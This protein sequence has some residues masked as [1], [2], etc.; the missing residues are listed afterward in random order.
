VTEE[1]NGQVAE[2]GCS[3]ASP[4]LRV[5]LKAT[6]RRSWCSRASEPAALLGG[7]VGF[8]A[9]FDARLLASRGVTAATTLSK[10]D[11]RKPRTG[12]HAV[13]A[14]PRKIVASGE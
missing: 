9:R 12:G 4:A 7:I 5:S 13:D 8:G 1:Q 3:R 6:R 2:G 14:R 10:I 11:I